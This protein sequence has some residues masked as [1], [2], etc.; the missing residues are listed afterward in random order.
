LEQICVPPIVPQ[1]VAVVELAV[2]D[3]VNVTVTLV[4]LGTQVTPVPDGTLQVS[5]GSMSGSLDV[6]PG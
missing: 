6:A 3:A 5:E 4:L 1:T 2:E